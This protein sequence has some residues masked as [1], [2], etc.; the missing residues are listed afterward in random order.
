M[1]LFAGCGGF[2]AGF[3]AAGYHVSAAI[4]YW[5]PATLTYQHNHP[6]TK[7]YWGDI[8][9]IKQELFA[10]FA[11]GAFDVI[12]GGPPCQG[13]SVAGNRNPEDPRGQLYT[14]FFKVVEFFRPEWFVMENVKGLLS[15]KHLPLDLPPPQEKQVT[16]MC[17]AIAEYKDLKRFKAQRALTEEEHQ[18]FQALEQKHRQLRARVKKTLVPLKDNILAVIHAIGYKAKYRVLNSADYG[19][20][21]KRERV[22]FI[23]TAG[24][25]SLSGIFPEPTHSQARVTT[26]DAFLKEAAAK[27]KKP[28][29]TVKEAL[30]DLVDA[31][32]DEALS[33]VFTRHKESFVKRIAQVKPGDNLYENYSDA[34]YRL[35]PDEPARTVKEN[36]GG[37]FLHYAR[38]RCVTP[39][40][41]ARLQSFPDTF[42][43]RGSKSDVLKQIGNAVPPKLA[44]AIARHLRATGRVN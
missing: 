39:R 42:R 33:H 12:V 27:P 28:W 3:H 26:L 19:V 30:D 2:S 38:P 17:A 43:F 16:R 13:Y 4:E 5:E 10:E 15:M 23:G 35:R 21:Q 18:R 31:P 11:P 34:W 8:R 32:E 20:P 22:F 7:L 36:H 29:V 40:E 24:A 14:E 25:H 9:E 37:V 41:L 44:Q 6:D 1:D